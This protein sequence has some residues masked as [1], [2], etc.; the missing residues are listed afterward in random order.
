MSTFGTPRDCN[1][2]C[3]ALI[4]FDAKSSV[5][6]PTAD[7]WLP[8]EYKEGRKTDIIHNCP[9]KKQNGSL[10]AVTTAVTTPNQNLAHLVSKLDLNSLAVIKAIVAALNEY[11]AIKEQQGKA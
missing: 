10:T 6:H 11:L 9:N 1:N 5:G 7:K 8:L 2:G 3:R 4:Y